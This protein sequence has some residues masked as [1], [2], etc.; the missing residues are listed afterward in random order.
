MGSGFDFGPACYY[1]TE[2]GSG[3]LTL[4]LHIIFSRKISR[5]DF[6]PGWF[7]PGSG[8]WTSVFL[9]AVQHCPQQ[10]LQP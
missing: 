2:M 7:Q 3:F 1:V 10:L 9:T 6:G 4:V 5:S 8:T